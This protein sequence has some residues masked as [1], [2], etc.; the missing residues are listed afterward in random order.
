MAMLY[1]NMKCTGRVCGHF[2]NMSSLHM[3]NLSVG[4]GGSCNPW[5]VLE[6]AVFG[7]DSQWISPTTVHSCALVCTFMH[8]IILVSVPRL[9]GQV[10]SGVSLSL[11]PSAGTL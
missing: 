2:K 3:R 8:R 4:G 1:S 6:T 11:L 5:D 9:A 10:V 7:Y